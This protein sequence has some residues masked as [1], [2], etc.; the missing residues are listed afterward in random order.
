[1]TEQ[2]WEVGESVLIYSQAWGGRS[3]ATATVTAVRKYG[4]GR[5]TKV[6]TTHGAFAADG[7]AWSRSGHY[8]PTMHKRDAKGLA[9]LESYRAHQVVERFRASG[10]AVTDEQAKK[11]AALLREIGLETP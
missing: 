7:R 9:D 4:A 6:T 10:A 11:L 5:R 8:P 3:I 1:M 2:T